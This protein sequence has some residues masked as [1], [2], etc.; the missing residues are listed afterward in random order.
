MNALKDAITMPRQKVRNLIK[1]I[2]Q[3]KL[4]DEEFANLRRLV[5]KRVREAAQM[6]VTRVDTVQ[7]CNPISQ[8]TEPPSDAYYVK[9]ENN[10]G[11][12]GQG[13]EELNHHQL[14]RVSKRP[15]SSVPR[16]RGY[17]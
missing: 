13:L 3:D 7:Y 5:E 2:E 1:A 14:V 12:M 4:S 15:N 11:K 17:G 6:T 10:E 16:P 8:T 9:L